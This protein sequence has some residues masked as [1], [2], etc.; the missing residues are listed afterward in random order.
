MWWQPSGWQS[1]KA[2]RALQGQAEGENSLRSVSQEKVVPTLGT[3]AGSH[4]SRVADW[5]GIPQDHAEGQTLAEGCQGR[6]EL[7]F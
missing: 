7:H 5:Q 1:P 3:L 4:P 6:P 2:G